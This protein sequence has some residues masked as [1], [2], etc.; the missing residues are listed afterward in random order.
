MI[1]KLREAGINFES[2]EKLN[3]IK[4]NSSN[5]NTLIKFPKKLKPSKQKDIWENKKF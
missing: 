5:K 1:D 4:L 3:S 2:N